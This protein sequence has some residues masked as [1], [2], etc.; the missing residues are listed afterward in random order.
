MFNKTFTHTTPGGINNNAL[1]SNCVGTFTFF[2]TMDLDTAQMDKSQI[3]IENTE[4]L[5]KQKLE[6]PFRF[7]TRK[8]PYQISVIQTEPDVRKQTLLKEISLLAELK[9][10]KKSR[11]AFDRLINP[12]S[13]PAD[14]SVYFTAVVD[15]L[16][17]TIVDKL[18]CEI[19]NNFPQGRIQ[20]LTG[21]LE[22]HPIPDNA[23]QELR[24]NLAIAKK[25]IDYV[26]DVVPFS[27]NYHQRSKIF[28][29]DCNLN[30]LLLYQKIVEKSFNAFIE[31]TKTEILCD[32]DLESEVK[33]I[34]E[35]KVENCWGMSQVGHFFAKKY[36]PHIPIEVVAINAQEGNHA[37]LIVGCDTKSNLSDDENCGDD[38][39][40]DVWT[41]AYYPRSEIKKYLM[42]FVH[43]I[44]NETQYTVVRHFN[45][46]TQSL[47][48]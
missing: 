13:T 10:C 24:K 3:L 19:K 31:E 6:N 46:S 18:P 8:R 35:Y 29:S 42:D 33:K 22:S 45:P 5:F 23:S 36:F 47:K 11:E 38:V 12:S 43:A 27:D 1:N 37:F 26:H 2:P 34:L 21:M 41:G 16:P 17:P 32:G 48:F 14:E 7:P 28:T 39:I 4:D 44:I 30:D 15:T 25:I 20:V 9:N 40:C